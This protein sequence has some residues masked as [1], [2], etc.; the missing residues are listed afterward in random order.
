MIALSVI[1]ISLLILIAA[2]YTDLKTLEVP[3][4]L[5]YFGIAAGIGIHLLW[6]MEQMSWNPI[7]SSL[8]GLGIGWMIGSFM[9]YTGQWGG[10][11]AKLLVAMG[12]LIGMEWSKTAF[13]TSYLINLVFLGGA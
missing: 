11:D 2:T 3:D 4:L 6:S 5:N 13:S 1:L 8:T 9:F 12:S 7:I 10:G